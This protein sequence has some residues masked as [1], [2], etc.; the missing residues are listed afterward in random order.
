MM[1]RNGWCRTGGSS[2]YPVMV[3][4][5]ERNI[6]PMVCY[7]CFQCDALLCSSRNSIIIRH[8]S[9]DT[10]SIEF[11]SVKLVKLRIHDICIFEKQ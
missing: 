10:I 7:E 3:L 8:F 1:M 11:Y 5:M 2:G 9:I 4:F 6:H